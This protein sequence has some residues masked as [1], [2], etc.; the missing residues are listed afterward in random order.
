MQGPIRNGQLVKNADGTL[1]GTPV[2]RFGYPTRLHSVAAARVPFITDKA[3]SSLDTTS[4]DWPD[5]LLLHIV[6]PASG[7]AS[8]NPTNTCPNTAHFVNGVLLGV[9]A[10]Y[11]DGHVETH[12]QAQMLCGYASAGSSP[13]WFY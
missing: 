12:N 11:A 9:N 10:A 8:S 1:I 7:I 13:Y 4:G 6:P 3:C 2:G 5:H